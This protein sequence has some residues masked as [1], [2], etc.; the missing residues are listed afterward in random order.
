MEVDKIDKEGELE[1][2]LMYIEKDFFVTKRE[3]AV[4]RVAAKRDN[5]EPR[6]YRMAYNEGFKA[7][8]EFVQEEFYTPDIPDTMFKELLEEVDN[9]DK[10][11]E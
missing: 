5:F 6:S 3:S 2:E 8:L 7:A 9:I 1:T 10:E 4:R 11:K